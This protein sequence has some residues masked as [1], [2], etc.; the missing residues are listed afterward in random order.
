MITN[1]EIE[2]AI[3]H[4]LLDPLAASLD[5]RHFAAAAKD[6]EVACLC[7]PPR[8]VTD[9]IA[10]AE[11]RI[12]VCSVIGFPNGYQHRAIKAAEARA[13]I[14]DGATEI[15][16]VLPLGAIRLHENEVLLSE[17]SAVREAIGDGVL[18]VIVE[19]GALTPAD[20]AYIAELLTRSDA[21]FIKTSTGFKYPGA[22]LVTV[23]MIKAIVGDRLRIKA[24]GGISDLTQARAY[25][26]L[27]VE[28]LGASRLL[29]ACQEDE[30]GSEI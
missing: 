5:V 11:G 18:K 26:A 8:Y 3:D 25:L 2:R 29:R 22:D 7:V 13:A 10:G 16:M 30:H 21:D 24:S 4:T 9:A 1:K 17:V 20:T 23:Q 27:G 28:R 15:D 14:R 6:S 19:T 12:P